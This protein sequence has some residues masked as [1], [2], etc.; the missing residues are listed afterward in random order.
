MNWEAITALS[1]AFTGLVIVVTA[2][3]GIDQ[4]RQLR[5][6]RRDSAAVELVR[7][8]QDIDF[9]RAF[10]LIFSL[11]PAIA[12]ADLRARGREYEEAAQLMVMRFEILGLLVYRGTIS[13]DVTEELIGGAVVGVWDRLKILTSET[14]KAQDYPM[15][16]E[17]FQWLA[18]QFIKRNRLEQSPAHVR[19]RD[20][21]PSNAHSRKI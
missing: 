18:E 4:L 3:V 6:Q 21:S 16:L 17:W 19:H 15:Y 12:A 10:G 1:A 20:W 5:A 9:T 11:P 13:F 2:L 7:S 8:L 14:R